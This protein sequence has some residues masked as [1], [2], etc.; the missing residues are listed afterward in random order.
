MQLEQDFV[1]SRVRDI[2]RVQVERARRLPSATF[3][4]PTPPGRSTR[5]RDA[6]VHVETSHQTGQ[7][8]RSTGHRAARSV[9]VMGITTKHQGNKA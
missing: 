9:T 5:P 3:S 6:V 7:E 4:T 2:N 1:S 8:S